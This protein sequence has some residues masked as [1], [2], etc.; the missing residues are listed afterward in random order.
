MAT[1]LGT[2]TGT[3]FGCTAETGI[4]INSFS[5]NA[6]SDKAEVR[7][8][9]GDVVLVSYYNERAEVSVAGTVAGTTGVTAA[10]VGAA[11]TLANIESVGG[12]S[13]GVVAVNSVSVSKKPDGFKD[14]NISA[15]RYKNI[16]AGA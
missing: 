4:L 9:D 7:D 6:T 11:L 8:A 10:V 3:T 1:L 5:I 16:T 12:V 15:T 14:I 13:T 2:S